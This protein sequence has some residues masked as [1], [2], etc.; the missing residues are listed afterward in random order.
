MT[1][2]S[3]RWTNDMGYRVSVPNLCEGDE[4][5]HVVTRDEY[6]RLRR[7]FAALAAIVREEYPD[8]LELSEIADTWRPTFS[9][10]VTD[11]QVAALCELED[12]A[13]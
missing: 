10:T 1:A 3:I 13:S 8:G 4:P 5:V 11:E 6:D 2:F 12:A 7:G 9:G